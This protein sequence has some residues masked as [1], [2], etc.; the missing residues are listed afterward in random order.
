MKFQTLGRDNLEYNPFQPTH[1]TH[2]THA[3][4][5]TMSMDDI[6][7]EIHTHVINVLYSMPR[8]SYIEHIR[9]TMEIHT[10]S[11]HQMTEVKTRMDA[12]GGTNLTENMH[13]ALWKSSSLYKRSDMHVALWKSSSLYRRSDN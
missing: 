11:V 12:L 8:E 7:A 1:P 13:V 4:T 9:R 6:A 3:I 2:P 5:L 10:A